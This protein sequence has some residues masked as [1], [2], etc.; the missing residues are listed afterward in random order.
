[1]NTSHESTKEITLLDQLMALF[2]FFGNSENL[3]L[4]QLEKH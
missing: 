2:E 1:M 3:H 4:R